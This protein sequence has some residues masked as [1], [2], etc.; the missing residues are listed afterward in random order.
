MTAPVESEALDGTARDRDD[1]AA[2]I[3]RIAAALEGP[4]TPEAAERIAAAR[5][6]WPENLRLMLLQGS[7]LEK[8]ARLDEAETCYG[9]A[10]A[11]H[12][13]NPWPA[14]RLTEL[15]L[16]QRRPKDAAGIFAASVWR[17]TAPEAARRSLLS[18]V[19]AALID[20]SDRRVFLQ[21]LLSDTADDRLVLPKLAALS[22]RERDRVEAERLLDRARQY[23]PLPSE[24]QM[25]WLELL[26]TATRF[27]EAF[28]LSMELRARH[29][30]R[31]EFTRRA[32]QAA[33]FSGR[34]P[35]MIALL[36]DAL[37]RWPG[38]W[39]LAFR[40]NR[41]TCPMAADRSLFELMSA[42][43]PA[44]TDQRWWFQYAI[45][46]LRHDRTDAARTILEPIKADSP[47][48]SMALP[49][50]AA[51]EAHPAATWRRGRGVVNDPERDVQSV[52]TAQARATLILLAGVQGGL[53][54]LPV[55]HVDGLLADL[56]VNVV[57]LRDLNNRAFTSGV[58]SMGPTQASMIA[59]LA[60]ICEP[61]AVPVI[62]FGASIGGVAAIRTALLLQAHAAIS[63][64]GPIHLG[65]D[66]TEDVPLM[67]GGGNA[68]T[69][70][71]SHFAQA[72][73][74]LIE[75]I[76]TVPR[77]RIHQ[78]FGTGYAPD[79]ADA[80]LM[81]PL[82]NVVLHPVARC[83]DHHVTEHMIADG[84]FFD[85]IERAI[86]MAR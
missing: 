46:C 51:L 66:T 75:M 76:R 19:A 28:D 67:N 15:F 85:V 12:P 32:I 52:R 53:G 49:L 55:S 20:L 10:L 5:R 11:G 68:K 63:F 35:Q 81:R 37:T 23:G 21:G 50:R 77:T 4:A 30:E 34:T 8:T 48:A 6:R 26:I 16:S 57:Y 14:L 47:V 83:A 17:S 2:N 60:K 24:C 84:S 38:D 25:L 56:A 71:F 61:L 7:W 86:T 39:L 31:S 54:Y 40:Y 80:E 65:V 59:A 78:C 27:D 74:S 82:S 43:A 36:H 73:L 79:V 42:Q 9:D 22:L 13:Q 29:P 41:C 45:A 18:R 69:T 62:T 72:D 3:S 70:L 64:A 58:R 1:L 33:H 44:A